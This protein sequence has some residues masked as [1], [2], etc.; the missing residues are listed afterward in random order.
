MQEC[1]NTG[2]RSAPQAAGAAHGRPQPHFLPARSPAARKLSP[3]GS[4][5]FTHTCAA[6]CCCCLLVVY[7]SRLLSSPLYNNNMVATRCAPA[8]YGEISL[9]TPLSPRK[10][11]GRVQAERDAPVSPQRGSR[12]DRL[13]QQLVARRAQEERELSLAV[14]AEEVCPLSEL[15]LDFGLDGLEGLGLEQDDPFS[16]GLGCLDLESIS[17]G[18]VWALVLDFLSEPAASPCVPAPLCEETGSETESEEDR[19]WDW[20]SVASEDDVEWGTEHCTS[21]G[22]TRRV[23]LVGEYVP[24]FCKPVRKGIVIEDT[25]SED[26]E[27]EAVVQ[28][29]LPGNRRLVRVC[30]DLFIVEPL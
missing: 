9:D 3:L 16:G 14:A 25:E 2:M 27:D 26:E 23:Y 1:K 17:Q 28:P 29:P 12:A 18:E 13:V 22:E 11:A 24:C 4:P 19:I 30:S 7:L 20:E 5:T 8:T 10:R 15:D 21:C 6:S